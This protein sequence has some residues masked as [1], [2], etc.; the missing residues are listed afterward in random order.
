MPPKTIVLRTADL[1]SAGD[2]HDFLNRHS[3]AIAA[4]AV[5]IWC[6]VACQGT[7]QRTETFTPES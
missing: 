2:G 5:L 6:D 4:A 7:R 3:P 1:S